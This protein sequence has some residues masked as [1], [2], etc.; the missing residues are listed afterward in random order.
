MERFLDYFAPCEYQLE[1][2]IFRQEERLKGKV[3]I[4]GKV[5][6]AHFIKLHAVDFGIQEI[7]WR[8]YWR[9]H[10]TESD[11]YGFM[12][13]DF[14]Y[15]NEVIK[16]PIT[17][18]MR[19][20]IK[21][22]N[23]D[24]DACSADCAAFDQDIDLKIIFSTKLNRNMEGCYLSSYNH[25]GKGR[26]IVTT[27]FE[28]HYAREAFPCID[29]PAAKAVF[30]LTLIVP[31]Y[32]PSCDVV[33]ANMPV[34][35]Q[36]NGRFD[37]APTPRMST[38]LLAWVIGPLQSVSSVNK[39]GVKVSSYCA[40]NQPLE[41]LLFAN[42][43]AVKSLEYYDEKFGVPYPLPKLDQVA[44][45]DF[46][47][48]AMENWGL[49]TYRESMMLAG[50]DAN[51]EL[52]RSIAITVTHELSHQWF[53]D[54]VTMAWWDDLWL[55]ESF[56]TIME[57]YAT[58]ALYPELNIW[59]EFFTADCLMALQRDS[60]RGIQ[61]VQQE[62][63]SPAEIATLFDVAIV[64]AKGARLILMLMRIMGEDNFYTGLKYYFE[65]YQY[66]NT[67]GDDLWRA[68][69]PYAD[70]DIQKFMHAWISQPGFPALQLMRNGDQTFWSQ[71][72]FFIDGTTDDSKWPLP[73]VK[74]DM[75][76]HYLIDLGNEEFHAKLTNFVELT[77]EQKLR[78]LIDRMLL[79]K[80]GHVPSDSLLE[81]LPKFKSE[82]SAA[83][84]DVIE[85]IIANLKVFIEP[86]STAEKQYKAFLR[87]LVS[88]GL[89][90]LN[91]PKELTTGSAASLDSNSIE[92][93]NHLLGLSC[94]AEDQDI[95]KPLAELYRPDLK[96]LDSE[97]RSYILAAKLYFDESQVFD[98]LLEQYQSLTDADLKAD[99]LYC[100]ATRSKDPAHLDTLISL[101]KKP[102][103]VRPQ[104]HLFLYVYLLRNYRSRERALD[105]LIE[106]WSYIESLAG[107]R[108]IED[109]IEYT[110]GTLRTEP[111][112]KKFYAFCDTLLGKPALT[113]AIET[114]HVELDA[115]LALIESQSAAVA[116]KLA[117]LTKESDESAA[118]PSETMA[119]SEKNDREA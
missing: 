16:I 71:Q 104:D 39:N 102:E 81:L 92:L 59:P 18:E 43:V 101:L 94:Y 28:S 118:K 23:A 83:V 2:C 87:N 52:K 4:T 72:R 69:Q 117:K 47:A 34:I 75:S 63:G 49:V 90:D 95:L 62:V 54:L 33:L 51:L 93:R 74:D 114:A 21:K 7:T 24:A 68:L 50:P 58:D 25:N 89:A 57:Y 111:S 105:W 32:D 27:Q 76:G 53:G 40:L 55:N 19:E 112:V 48:G 115:R 78:L 99:I 35:G 97:L 119:G 80:A 98:Y 66:K 8:P 116:A 11:N 110:A 107:D 109:Y 10:E 56:A 17:S 12:K 5:L 38:Y 15:D 77:M 65:R 103:T 96:T 82:S 85:S 61:S 46:E 41:S 30:D 60:L 44:L 113:R 29:E 26:K 86:G 42:E 20:I 6:N 106:N 64:Y 91:F 79:A 3:E 36:V 31:D 9:G 1:E 14:Q 84:W 108:S 45:P 88:V 100:L 22:C 67:T 13:C 37:F 73:E 70:F